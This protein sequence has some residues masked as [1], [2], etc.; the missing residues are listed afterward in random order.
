MRKSS[1]PVLVTILALLCGGF[2]VRA[3][4]VSGVLSD[5]GGQIAGRQLH[6]QNHATRDIYMAPTSN[7]GAFQADLP[8]GSYS[9]RGER[10]KIFVPEIVVIGREAVSLG[11]VNQP[12]GFNPLRIFQLEGVVPVLVYTPAP[13]TAYLRS[14]SGMVSSILTVAPVTGEFSQKGGAGG[15]PS[16]APAAATNS[17]L[18]PIPR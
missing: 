12:T 15:A 17:K 9:L 11:T 6:F 8:P 3:A 4:Q 16:F 14:E 1:I 7:H 13:S 18:T 10:G 5:P 2:N